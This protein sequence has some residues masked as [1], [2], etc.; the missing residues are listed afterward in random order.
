MTQIAAQ[1]ATS[2]RRADLDW[3]RVLAVLLL[4]PYHSALVFDLDPNAVVFVKDVVQSPALVEAVDFVHRRHMPLLFAIAGAA[5][6]FALGWRSGGA[7]LG[8][9]VKRLLV[10][11]VF[12]TL[13]LVPLMLNVHW[14]GRPDA[15]SLGE[16]YR[17]FLT[18]NPDDLS[19]YQGTFAPGHLWFVGDLLIFSLLALPLFLALRRPGPQRVLSTIAAWPGAVYLLVIPQYLVYPLNILGNAIPPYYLVVFCCGYLL[20]ASPR[21]QEA[22][23]GQLPL[24]TVLALVSTVISA[25]MLRQSPPP[26]RAP[27]SWAARSISSAAGPGCW[28]SSAP[29]TAGWIAR[30]RCCAIW[31]RP[32]IPSTSC[33]SRS[34]CSSPSSSSSCRPLSRSSSPSSSS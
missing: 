7:Y 1:A 8:E 33:T 26:G 23:D 31:P 18:L 21:F 5:S 14:L 32:P 17:R 3:V 28:P 19:G 20:M 12:A 2:K 24:S 25:A 29:A 6:W 4:V 27:G 22:I 13:T 10:P 9:R 34:T 16:M 11:F 15:P 30:A